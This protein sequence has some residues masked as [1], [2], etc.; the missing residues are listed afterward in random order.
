M[1]R[2]LTHCNDCCEDIHVGEECN[3][4]DENVHEVGNDKGAGHGGDGDDGDEERAGVA[5]H[6]QQHHP[7]PHAQEV[8]VGQQELVKECVLEAC[9]KGKSEKERRKSV[10]EK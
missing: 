2:W 9:G 4:V 10:R 6:E 5:P 1:S 7:A 8:R 3:L